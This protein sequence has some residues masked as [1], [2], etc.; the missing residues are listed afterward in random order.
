[1]VRQ[2]AFHQ[3]L[4]AIDEDCPGI[5]EP[6]AHGCLDGMLAAP[7]KLIDL[8]LGEFFL[9]LVGDL[10]DL[11]SVDD[12][13]HVAFFPQLDAGLVGKFLDFVEL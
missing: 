8:V 3:A 1:M 6:N 4:A 5:L 13:E 11:I 12:L 2:V 10:P 9:A 7:E